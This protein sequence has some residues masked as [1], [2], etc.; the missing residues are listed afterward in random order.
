MLG[1]DNKAGGS[2]NS[3]NSEP[4]NPSANNIPESDRKVG[5]EHLTKIF[6]DMY[7]QAHEWGNKALQ[8]S[9]KKLK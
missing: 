8:I 5:A 4:I 2:S 9:D 3:S 1:G 6:M 7:Q